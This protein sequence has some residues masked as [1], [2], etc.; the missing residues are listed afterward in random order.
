MK[1]RIK[2]VATPE[3]VILALDQATHCG[4]ALNIGISG[5][6]D[7]TVKK[8]ESDGMRLIRFRSKVK[9]II[10][11]ENVQLVVW[12]RPAGRHA[13]S[14]IVSAELQGQIKTICKDAGIEHRAYSATEV[15]KFATGKGNA[16]KPAMVA[17]A[18]VK[19]GYTGDNDDEADALWIL[20]LA[21][22]DYL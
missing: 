3:F 17:A 4:W 13:R 19:L 6:W 20:E 9:E 12:E 15:K 16:G 11:N 14:I 21:K 10:Q 1:R 8:D 7:L 2:P 22:H 5:V 18:Q